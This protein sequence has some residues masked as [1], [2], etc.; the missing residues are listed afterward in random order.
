MRKTAKLTITM[1]A[2]DEYCENT[3]KATKKQKIEIIIEEIITF[4]KLLKTR[5]DDRAGKI[6]KLDINNVPM[7]LIP[8]TTTT[9]VKI[10]SKIL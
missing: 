4:L 3:K 6:I 1:L 8:T 10:D 5:I 2:A 7:I 9:A